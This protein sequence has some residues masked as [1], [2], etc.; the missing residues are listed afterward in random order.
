MKRGGINWVNVFAVVAGVCVLWLIFFPPVSFGHFKE[1]SGSTHC[2]S[3]IKQIGTAAL[4][5][6]NNND[7]KLPHNQ[8]VD[9]V[10]R[11]AKNMEIFTCSWMV[12]DQKKWGFAMNLAVMGKETHLFPEPSRTVM[13]FEIDAFAKDIVANLAARARARH[14][15]GDNRF[16]STVSFV[17]SSAR[18]IFSDAELTDHAAV[19]R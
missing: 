6:A 13:F 5:Y 1:V 14:P 4:I 16:G 19:A 15:H 12:R 11:Y 3:N 18:L 2:L 17:D 10:N 8:W 9:P 7:G